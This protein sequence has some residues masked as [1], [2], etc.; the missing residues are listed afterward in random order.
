MIGPRRSS[1]SITTNSSCLVCWIGTEHVM[2][3]LD[4]GCWAGSQ[5]FPSLLLNCISYHDTPCLCYCIR[6]FTVDMRASFPQE[7]A[8]FD[9][10]AGVVSA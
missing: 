7:R 8:D 3:L 9:G 5:K 4:R 2:N 10:H 1:R 6:R